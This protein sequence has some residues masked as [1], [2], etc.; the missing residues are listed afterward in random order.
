MNLSAVNPD[1][2]YIGFIIDKYA[3]YVYALAVAYSLARLVVM[4]ATEARK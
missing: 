1:L 2:L 3:A 4:Y